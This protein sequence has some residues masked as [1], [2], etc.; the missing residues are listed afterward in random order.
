VTDCRANIVATGSY[1]P[2]HVVRNEDLTQ[3]PASALP[4]I[5]EKTGVR[6]RRHAAPSQCTSDLA[7]EAGRNALAA[8]GW[9]P[10]SLDALLLATSSPD[11]I[12]PATATRVQELLGARQAFACDVGSVCA[13][14]VYALHL[15]DGLIRAESARRVLVAASEVYSRILN[16]KDFS[17]YPYF[18]DGAGAV[19]LE[20]GPGPAGI[21]RSRLGSDG[22]RDHVI[23]IPAGG[24]M[25]PYG[26]LGHPNDVYF[27]MR[28]R[29]VYEFAVEQGSAVV[30]E[31]LAE[32]GMVAAD[33][34]HV[35]PHQANANVIRDL[36]ERLGIG[37]DRFVVNLDRYGNTAGASV[38]IGLDELHRSGQLQKGDAT[39]LVAF[40]GGLSWGASLIQS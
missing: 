11:R 32:C 5:E 15:A 26:R 20:A 29:E 1:L 30:R 22:S 27:K 18:G 8:A 2:E 6:E 17:T 36:A 12:Q 33:V 3:F 9:A 13:G 7:A 40:G 10:E 31:L 19:L 23:Q 21:V 39:V 28:G 25:L 38:L 24:T 34:H 16:P 37:L 35:V 14:A 4:R